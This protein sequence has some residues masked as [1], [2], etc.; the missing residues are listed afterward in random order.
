MIVDPG[1]MT[2]NALSVRRLGAHE[3]IPLWG[4]QPGEPPSSQID[5][6]WGPQF[7]LRFFSAATGAEL[8]LVVGSIK[9]NF[10][11]PVTVAGNRVFIQSKKAR[12]FFIEA[13]LLTGVVIEAFLDLTPPPIRALAF[14]IANSVF[15][16]TPATTLLLV[17]AYDGVQS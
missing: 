11:R 8:L 17:A 16:T 1:L 9:G 12:I 15:R 14:A 4:K 7:P 13:P 10:D 2:V 6:R 3:T 5:L